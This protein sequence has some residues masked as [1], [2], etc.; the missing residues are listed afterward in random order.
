MFLG[1]EGPHL[2]IITSANHHIT[3][4]ITVKIWNSNSWLNLLTRVFILWP[5]LGFMLLDKLQSYGPWPYSPFL[6]KHTFLIW[7]INKITNKSLKKSRTLSWL[8]FINR[9]A[10]I[11]SFSYAK[12]R[13]LDTCSNSL[14][15]TSIFTQINV[16][17]Q[18]E[19]CCGRRL[20]RNNLSGTYYLENKVIYG[21][22]LQIY[23]K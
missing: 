11:L 17:L 2:D 14:L 10:E 6:K 12:L 13:N 1:R 4:C 5:V 16:Q 22:S 9:N 19:N 18:T 23:T 8:Y 15:K 7:V 20:G 21:V 3:L